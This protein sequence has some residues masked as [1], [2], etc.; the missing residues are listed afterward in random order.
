[1]SNTVRFE[2]VAAGIEKTVSAEVLVSKKISVVK[3]DF[4]SGVVNVEYENDKGLGRGKSDAAKDNH[5][6][7][8]VRGRKSRGEEKKSQEKPVLTDEEK[9]AKEDADK[10]MAHNADVD[11]NGDVSTTEGSSAL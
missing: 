9:Q 4:D 10:E 2:I 1:M 7:T 11:L 6:E 8:A 3:V 5:S